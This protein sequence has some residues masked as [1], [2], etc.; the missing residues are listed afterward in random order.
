MGYRMDM[1]STECEV[2]CSPPMTWVMT[3]AANTPNVEGPQSISGK[4]N[5]EPIVHASSGLIICA[6]LY[7]RLLWPLSTVGS[8]AELQH[9]FFQRHGE[10][11]LGVMPPRP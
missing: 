11:P 10:S 8:D 9:T 3:T 6:V 7:L 1:I 4:I 5:D 2:R